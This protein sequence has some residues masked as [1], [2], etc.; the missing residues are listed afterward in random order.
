MPQGQ[1]QTYPEE[2]RPCLSKYWKIYF[3]DREISLALFL[4]Y[5]LK[6]ALFIHKTDV[7]Y[8]QKSNQSWDYVGHGFILVQPR[9]LGR[10]R[11]DPGNE[12]DF[13]QTFILSFNE[14]L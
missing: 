9:S 6:L 8:G 7:Q 11:E 14:A 10:K 12:A 3:P 5:F 1:S 13:G 2:E 4:D